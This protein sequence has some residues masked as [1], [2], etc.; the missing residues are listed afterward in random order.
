MRRKDNKYG[1]SSFTEEEL[2]KYLKWLTIPGIL[3]ILVLVVI[4]AK[5]LAGGSGT[6]SSQTSVQAEQPS[7]EGDLKEGQQEAVTAP[8]ESGSEQSRAYAVD[9]I[10]AMLEQK[11][12][13]YKLKL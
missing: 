6:D 9:V 3:I 13:G 2:R 1:Y 10:K 12:S 11:C 8:A 7:G 4:L 5:N